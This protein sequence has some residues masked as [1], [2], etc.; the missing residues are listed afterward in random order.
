VT[1]DADERVA[2]AA[3]SRI[4]E[5]GSLD[6]WLMVHEMGAAAALEQLRAGAAREELVDQL[7]PS[8][9]VADPWATAAK[10]LD[11]VS[12]AGARFVVPGDDEWPLAPLHALLLLSARQ[13]EGAPRHDRNVAPPLGLWVRG[14]AML[15]SVCERSV[16][17]VGA[18]S[19][20]AYGAHVAGELAYGLA[21]R[22]WAVISG[23]AYG[24]DAAAHRGA[25]AADGI[26]VAILASGIDT[27]Y[28]VAHTSLF[29]RIAETG[30]LVTE[31]PPGSSPRRHRFLV[32]NRVIAALT[33]GTVVVEAAVRSGARATARRAAQL[34]RPLMAVPGPVTSAMSMGAHELMREWGA[35]VVCSVSHVLEEVG[36]IG[37]DLGQPPR[38]PEVLRDELDAGSAALLDVLTCSPR[39]VG[40]IAAEA[41]LPESQARTL[42]AG[43]EGRGLAEAV[44]GE[45]RISV[46]GQA[47]EVRL[48]RP[49]VR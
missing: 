8:I 39:D 17:L 20:T 33:R 27:A 32:R 9:H 7:D 29:E 4:V 49:V 44:D 30:L 14:P 5:P 18:R 45:F 46:L 48:L 41:R 40:R 1:A 3:L 35:R 19:C 34:G 6:L 10:D 12:R 38:A 37:T 31:W 43:L 28:P 24:I 2:R 16:A 36:E 26:T 22:G 42:L 25:A 13:A 11:L 23:G 21:D 15:R 47:S